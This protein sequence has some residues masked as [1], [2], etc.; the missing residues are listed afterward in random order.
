M[1]NTQKNTTI[2]GVK[3]ASLAMKF[4]AISTVALLTACASAPSS[5]ASNTAKSDDNCR[6][7]V[8][9]STAGKEVD[10]CFPDQ[11]KAC[12]KKGTFVN[13]E[14]LRRMNVGMNEDQVRELISY[15]HFNEGFFS[16]SVWNYVFNFRTGAGPDYITCQYQVQYKDGLTANMYWNKPGCADVLVPKVAEVVRTVTVT[17]PPV[18]V[19]PAVPAETVTKPVA[20]PKVAPMARPAKQDRN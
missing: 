8:G 1:K 11:S 14:S 2:A 13:V 19:V 15:P 20:A 17:A 12:L 6:K 3:I 9:Q 16:P 7:Q 5:T 4:V 18:P 10:V